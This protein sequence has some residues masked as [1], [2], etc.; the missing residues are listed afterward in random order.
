MFTGIIQ[1]TGRIDKIIQENNLKKIEI[2]AKASKK[3]L[4]IGASVAVNGVCLTVV[5]LK[6][7]SFVVE[8]IAATLKA[9]TL[10][11]LKV[12]DVVNLETA[13]PLGGRLD[14]HLVSGHVDC[15]GTIIRRE[16]SGQH[17]EFYVKIPRQYLVYVV[18]KGSIC[19]DG[20]SLTINAI[21]GEA[22]KL[23][24]IPHTLKN[25]ILLNRGVNHPVNIEFDLLGKY[26]IA[27]ME[28]LLNLEQS[29]LEARFLEFSKFV[30][31]GNL[32]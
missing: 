31:R 6:W 20:V 11:L 32:N 2:R 25:T 3:E 30:Y 24:V 28:S 7:D 5:D 14:G 29:Q 21:K 15:L 12:G 1:E 26:A 18:E 13:L 27:R 9:T 8:V 22:I 17:E 4:K 19:V 23:M 16:T 10:G